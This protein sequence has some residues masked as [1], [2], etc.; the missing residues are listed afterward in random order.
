MGTPLTPLPDEPFAEYEPRA[1]VS[2]RPAAPAPDDPPWGVGEGALLWLSSFMLLAFVPLVPLLAYMKAKGQ[3]V[4]PQALSAALRTDPD[5]IFASVAGIVPAHVLTA[6]LA[7][8]VV[9]RF[10]RRPF[11]RT[12]GWD[13][14]PRFGFWT[15][16]GLA[17]ALLVAGYLIL[18][19]V[20]GSETE[21]DHIIASS[22]RARFMTAFL[23]TVTAPFVEEL[24]YRGVLFAPLRRAAGALWAVVAVSTLFALVHVWQYQN[25]LGVIATVTLLSFTLT[26]VRA[27]T[28]RLLPCFVIH[29]VFN[30]LQSLALVL[31]HFRPEIPD[32]ATKTAGLLAAPV[33]R[34]LS[35]ALGLQL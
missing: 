1:V 5:A 33:A 3:A 20:G 12:L 19:S 11:W 30:G 10:G 28:G 14:A 8:A 34:A 22:P 2:P 25:N 6:A 23:A 21:L 16:A 7:W 18:R 24:V 32:E 13:F 26:A 17:V 15:S 9:T 31:Q 27:A 4:T 29:V 35:S